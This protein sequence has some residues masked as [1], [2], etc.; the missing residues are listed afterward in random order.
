MRLAPLSPLRA[1]FLGP[2][3]AAT[4][5]GPSKTTPE[6]TQFE[7]SQSM[8]HMKEPALKVVL[9]LPP[10]APFSPRLEARATP[11]FRVLAYSDERVMTAPPLI[12]MTWPDVARLMASVSSPAVETT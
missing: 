7:D 12:Q 11:G 4:P 2:D 3:V 9:I 6:T 10:V 1:Q 8:G 5:P